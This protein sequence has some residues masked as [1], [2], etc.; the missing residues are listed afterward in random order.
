MTDVNISRGTADRI[1]H[2]FVLDFRGGP[3]ALSSMEAIYTAISQHLPKSEVVN[4]KDYSTEEQ[5]LAVALHTRLL[6][7]YPEIKEL[8]EAYKTHLP[9]GI[10]FN[11]YVFKRF[12]PVHFLYWFTEPGKECRYLVE[13]APLSPELTLCTVPDTLFTRYVVTKES[14]LTE[15]YQPLFKA[16]WDFKDAY[17]DLTSFQISHLFNTVSFKKW[18][19]LK[20]E[21]KLDAFPEY[22]R[23]KKNNVG[24][25]NEE[26]I[27]DA[28][29]LIEFVLTYASCTKCIPANF[30]YYAGRIVRR[31]RRTGQGAARSCMVV[32]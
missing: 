25:H 11:P 9:N 8:L 18:S 12:L 2:D 26:L 5:A 1:L 28:M 13:K 30:T 20:E 22:Y 6:M 31:E 29:H 24:I 27:N 19:M 7:T 3:L 4:F 10:I 14:Y 23:I 17:P 32:V 16:I 21:G 15:T